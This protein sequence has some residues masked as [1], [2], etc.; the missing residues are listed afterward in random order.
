MQA[1][2]RTI[3]TTEITLNKSIE[4]Y[5]YL[6]HDVYSH[7][8]SDDK[9]V[10]ITEYKEVL[11]KIVNK[12]GTATE[13][14]KMRAATPAL[15]KKYQ[16]TQAAFDKDKAIVVTYGGKVMSAQEEGLL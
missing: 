14:E 11:D 4:V 10:Y 15:V 12:K 16:E 6:K 1:R 5:K 3:A 2:A 9:P 8:D 7:Q 13:L